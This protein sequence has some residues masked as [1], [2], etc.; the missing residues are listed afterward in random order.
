MNTVKDL[1]NSELLSKDDILG[2]DDIPTELV[3]VPEWK[4]R[5]VMISG[6]T[7]AGKNAYQSSLVE[8]NGKSRKLKLEHSTAKLLVRTLVDANRQ[9][10]FTETD[11]IRLGTKSSAVL[12][13]LAKVASRLSGMDEQE[14]EAL[15]KNS[16]AAQSDDSP[17]DSL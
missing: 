4:G 3:S 1:L 14:N 11:I 13:R 8:L 16:E 2:M 15:A 6:M 7:A 5:T 17:I 12:E 9:P 10:L